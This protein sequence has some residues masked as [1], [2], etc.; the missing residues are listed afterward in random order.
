[1][2]ADVG[3]GAVAGQRLA[4]Q[5]SGAVLTPHGE[6]VDAVGG[7]RPDGFEHIHLFGAHLVRLKCDRRLHRHQTHQLEEVILDHVAQGAGAVVVAAAVLHA[8]GLGDGDLHR[9]HVARVP[10]GLEQSVREAESQD[11]LDGLLAQVVVDAVDLRLGEVLPQRR[12]Q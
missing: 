10:Y 12:V 9:V 11:V 2:R 6:L 7:D 3:L 5:M 1:M 4:D 8:D